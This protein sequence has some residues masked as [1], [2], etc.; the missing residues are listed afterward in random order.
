[1]YRIAGMIGMVVIASP[2]VLGYYASDLVALWYSILAGFGLV[3][4]AVEA[5]RAER[6]ERAR[7]LAGSR[8][9]GD[10]WPVVVRADAYRPCHPRLYVVRSSTRHESN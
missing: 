5:P 3:L 6:V 8:R 10:L 9:A 2:F 4:L 7:R 1:M